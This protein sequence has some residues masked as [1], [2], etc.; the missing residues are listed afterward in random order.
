MHRREAE[1]ILGSLGLS[2]NHKGWWL[3]PKVVARGKHNV[4]EMLK[5]L[6]SGSLVDP[7]SVQAD[8]IGVVSEPVKV[9]EP[10][11]SP[12]CL[13]TIF[14]LRGGPLDHTINSKMEEVQMGDSSLNAT[15]IAVGSLLAG[16]RGGYGGG[17]AWGGSGWTDTFTTPGAN[18]VRIDRNASEAAAYHAHTLSS[19]EFGNTAIRDQFDAATRAAQ[20][21]SIA[22][23][24]NEGDVRAADQ[25]F[26]SE[27]RTN[28][29][30]LALQAEINQNARVAADCCCDLKLQMCEDKSQVL[31]SI[32]AV[33][34]RA[35][36]RSLNAA[37]AR[38]TQ[39]ETINALSKCFCPT[40]A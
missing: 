31:A 25:R 32:A 18:S 34:S 1:A 2:S 7:V 22:D 14:D 36:E 10:F 26:Q 5:A 13:A 12:E 39:L 37:N 20:F 15:E 28:D 9:L 24:I 27:L 30:L 38:I 40:V 4:S 17:G 19:M 6:Y 33:E 16:G 8:P 29:R 35:V 3:D 23:K 11:G 21:S